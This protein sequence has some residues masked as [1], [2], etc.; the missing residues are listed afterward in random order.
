VVAIEDIQQI[1]RGRIS[2]S[3]P[4]GKYTS[5][6]IGGPADFFLEP[7]D[8]DDAVA[9]WRYLS[10]H[11]VPTIVLGNGSN[12]LVADEGWRGAVVSLESGFAGV[13]L[14]GRSVVAGAGI[15]L[16]AFVDF[17]IANRFAGAEMLAGIPGTLGG[18]VVMNA[19][20]YGGE[21]SDHLTEVRLIRRGEPLTV[22]RGE[23]GF[24][25]RASDLAGAVVLEARFE[26][27]AGDP[28][29]MRKRR[30]ELMIKRNA[31][32]PVEV[33][34]AGSIFKNPPGA[35][36]AVL[37]EQCGGKGL[38]EGG[39]VVSD[40]H[41]NFIVNDRGAAARDV[42][43][44]IRRVRTLVRECV[45]IELQLEVKLVGFDAAEIADLR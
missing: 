9:I 25:Y 43:T 12:V 1:S 2:L 32:Q 30:R 37:I 40:R 35:Y 42:V 22:A 19:G 8:A 15:R 34:N 27:P 18:A 4:L 21:I 41:A 28:D 33:P 10:A 6:R 44:L 26:F 11:D 16:A 14:D 7:V 36:A 31:S 5:F 24:R 38:R 45:G 39:A 20:A 17:C 3:E 29:E 13:R 23:A